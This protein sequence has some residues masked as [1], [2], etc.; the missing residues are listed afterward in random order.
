MGPS[1]C[2]KSSSVSDRQRPQRSAGP[3]HAKSILGQPASTA[4]SPRS[5]YHR[6]MRRALALV[7]ACLMLIGCGGT[8][9]SFGDPIGGS[10]P[11]VVKPEAVVPDATL[12]D[13]PP[14]ADR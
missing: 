12:P 8:E 7:V 5:P 6:R 2:G 13:P 14:P 11:G 4:A 1:R 3:R 10:P 9:R